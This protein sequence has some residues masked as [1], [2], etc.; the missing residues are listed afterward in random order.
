MPCPKLPQQ[1][2]QFIAI[3]I[4]MGHQM[5]AAHIEPLDRIE[6]FAET[7]FD[8]FQCQP[9]VFGTRLAQHM[10]MQSLNADRQAA[11]RIQ[12]LGRNTQPRACDTRIIKVCFDRRILRI[13]A[14][15]ARNAVNQRPLTEPLEL[16]QR[17][18]RDVVAVTHDFVETGIG[19]NG[20]IRVRRTSVLLRHE[21]RFGDG[22][23]RSTVGML[24]QF[25]KNP[26]HGAGFERNDDFDTRF[27]P[28]TVNS[29]KI[30]IEQPLIE[31]IARR[32]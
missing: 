6:I 4:G 31:H 24:R 9:E 23:C 8:R 26:P 1:C 22:T 29:S 5:P 28:H 17:V 12:F 20:C 11:R 32:R 7:L 27:A 16:R 10:E 15:S 14:Q 25:G 21:P 19:V 18:E 13:D 3:V 30:R 2:N